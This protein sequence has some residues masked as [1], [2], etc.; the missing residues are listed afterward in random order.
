MIPPRSIHPS[1][2]NERGLAFPPVRIVQVAEGLAARGAAVSVQSICQVSLRSAMTAF[3]RAVA[4]PRL[5]C[6]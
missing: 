4:T 1:C 2:S 6:E 5:A 3:V